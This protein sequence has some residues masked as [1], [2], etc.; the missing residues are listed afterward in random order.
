[1]VFAAKTS[2]DP[3]I[4]V[5]GI[6]ANK[7]NGIPCIGQL[8]VGN[9]WFLNYLF[10]ISIIFIGLTFI[11]KNFTSV[12]KNIVVN[13]A[14]RPTLLV[15]K[16]SFLLSGLLALSPHARKVAPPKG[17][18]PEL[19]SLAYYAKIFFV[20]VWLYCFKDSIS[21]LATKSLSLSGII[22]ACCAT[23]I[24]VNAGELG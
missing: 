9:L 12:T 1:M 5:Q 11:T 13:F 18:V 8:P 17:L 7:S 4:L 23:V 22:S 16:L 6:M 10:V 20:G 24:F 3:T 14:T 19:W 21:S 15:I 2:S